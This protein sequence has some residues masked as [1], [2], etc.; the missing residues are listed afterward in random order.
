MFHSFV[1]LLLFL[2]VVQIATAQSIS[3]MCP[4]YDGQIYTDSTSQ[5]Y[6][7]F[8]NSD[9]SPGSYSSQSASSFAACIS[10][11]DTA[12]SACQ[13]VTWT[14]GGTCYLKNSFS[15]NVT[16]SGLY[17]AVKYNTP[18][19]PAPQANY[20]NASSG[21]GTA[22]PAGQSP[23]GATQTVNVTVGGIAR[24]YNIHI[25]FFYNISKAAPL[26]MSFHGRTS[27]PALNEEESG[28]STTAWNPYGIVVYPAGLN[29]GGHP[30]AQ[31]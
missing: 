17:S 27:T 18:A 21:C 10:L 12:G 22:L 24:S 20:V 29:V 14:S 9:T 11:C 7:I 6:L 13:V 4:T 23:N 31:Q 25:P 3:P 8:C 30:A 15:S 1:S 5:R 16:S 19:Y 2:G 28:L 26:I